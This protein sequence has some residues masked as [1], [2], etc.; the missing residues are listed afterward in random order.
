M[1]KETHAVILS[2][3]GSEHANYCYWTAFIDFSGGNSRR[4][5]ISLLD[6]H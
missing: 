6:D 1:D 5:W 2:I 4:S 3:Y